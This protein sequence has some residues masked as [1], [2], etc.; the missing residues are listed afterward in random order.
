MKLGPPSILQ[1]PG[2]SQVLYN[3]CILHP[4]SRSTRDFFRWFLRME[5]H[6]TIHLL[7]ALL[8]SSFPM[9]SMAAGYGKNF[10][11]YTAVGMPV[12]LNLS[13]W[14]PIPI[15]VSKFP[16]P[17]FGSTVALTVTLDITS[18]PSNTAIE[19][20]PA[21]SSYSGAVLAYNSVPLITCPNVL[22]T[23]FAD[24]QKYQAAWQGSFEIPSCPPPILTGVG[25]WYYDYLGHSVT[26][27]QTNTPLSHLFS[28]RDINAQW[29]LMIQ[30]YSIGT[31]NSFS[32][33]LYSTCFLSFWS[34]FP[35]LKTFLLK[36]GGCIGDPCGPHGNCTPIGWGDTQYTC[37]CDPGFLS[38]GEGNP[39]NGESDSLFVDVDSGLHFFSLSFAFLACP[40]NTYYSVVGKCVPCPL[41]MTS[42][43]GSAQSSECV[44][45][46]LSEKDEASQTCVSGC[47]DN[48]CTQ[49][50]CITTG[51][52]SFGCNCTGTGYFGETCGIFLP[53]IV[54]LPVI[55]TVALGLYF[56]LRWRHPK[57]KNSIVLVVAG[58]IGDIVLSCLFTFMLATYDTTIFAASLVFLVIPVVF[59]FVVIVRFL[60]KSAT[61]SK[62]VRV[63]MDSNFSVAST[64]ALLSSFNTDVFE[65]LHSRLFKMGAFDAPFTPANLQIL[66]K[67]ALLTVIIG[68]VPQLVIQ[69]Y[70]GSKNM[71]TV[72]FFSIIMTLFMII[73]KSLKYALMIFVGALSRSNNA[74]ED[75]AEDTREDLAT[76]YSKFKDEEETDLR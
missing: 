49:G 35:P 2:L 60:F 69:S 59:N 13:D 12:S 19:L 25:D 46:P 32:V 42:P 22:S 33:Q 54:V 51:P 61:D 73:S 43:P 76:K 1:Q 47:S 74:V 29:W 9:S 15:V 36:T 20:I 17:V 65:I 27:P 18:D 8:V 75:V 41:N 23:T 21:S 48:P 14:T 67:A 10:I 30:T 71:T 40:N 70:V 55:I 39:C 4:S 34:L 7:L 64:V 37:L 53:A 66:K 50:N 44:C 56:I 68:D 26:M 11:Q 72:T 58:T 45:P 28:A 52:H 31:L 24:G 57:A 5:W 63:W 62:E 38:L 6:W 3:T 16:I